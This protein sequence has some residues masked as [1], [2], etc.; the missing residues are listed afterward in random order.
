M[1]MAIGALSIAYNGRGPAAEAGRA[2]VAG[3][4]PER[5]ERQLTAGYRIALQRVAEVEPC[6]DLFADLGADGVEMLRTT[7]YVRPRY[8]FELRACERGAVAFTFVGAPQTRLCDGFGRLADGNAAKLLIHEALH[9]AGLGEQPHDPDGP[10]PD[11]INRMV[12]RS[13]GL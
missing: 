7:I 13:C 2:L 5:V 8:E 9:H 3:T 4:L 12:A 11:Q 10:T 1:G 6:R